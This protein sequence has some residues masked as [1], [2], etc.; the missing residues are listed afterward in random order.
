MSVLQF[1]RK[2]EVIA[3][4][5]TPVEIKKPIPLKK[6]T[7]EALKKSR[8]PKIFKRY[9][10]I[11]TGFVLILAYPF[12]VLQAN[13]ISDDLNFPESIQQTWSSPWAGVGAQLLEREVEQ[14][15]WANDAPIWSP[16]ARLTAMPAYQKAIGH[17]IGDYAELVNEELGGSAA[18]DLNTVALLLSRDISK[19][20]I[21]AA[22]E[23]LISFN[24]GVRLHRYDDTLTSKRYAERVDLM[25]SW[26]RQSTG[27]LASVINS[28]DRKLFEKSAIE[29]V[30]T[31]KARAYVAHR[32]LSIMQAPVGLSIKNEHAEA[33]SQLE[34][35]A[36]FK[37]LL[38]AN[39]KA[40]GMIFASHPAALYQL[41]NRVEMALFEVAE[42]VESQS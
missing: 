3:E 34:K 33:I 29:A 39:G 5:P 14:H 37:P 6:K 4:E 8:I 19:N 31:A 21:R 28:P 26:M 20:E 32:F 25:I 1:S 22:S 41:L 9:L 23:A 16:L 10:L 7:A 38:V 12:M 35:A 24:G 18:A 17:A 15:G 13:K 2:S 27:E 40:D 36:S 11:A 30:Y 42:A